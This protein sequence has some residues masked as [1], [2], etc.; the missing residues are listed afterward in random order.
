MDE[1]KILTNTHFNTN[2]NENPFPGLRAFKGTESHLFFGREENISDVLA[3][4]D[5]SHFVAVV[6]TSGTGK[7]SLIKAGVLPAIIAAQRGNDN[8]E[9]KVISISPGSSPIENLAKAVCQN[10]SLV[11]QSNAA[12]Y[13]ANLLD[14]MNDNPLGLVQ[15]MRPILKSTEKLLI[16]V[17]Q[18]EEVFRF[19]SEEA[20]E[21]RGE[22]DKFVKLIID[23]VRQ[24]DVPI[25]AIL[26]LRSDFLGDCVA[27]EGLPEAINDG[28]YLVPK[29]TK[30]QLKRA[31]TGPIDYSNGKIS[32]RL[33]QHITEYLGS[34]ANSDQLPI[35]QHAMMRCWD[36]WKDHE[37]EGEPLDIKHFKAIGDLE[38]AMSNH[39]NEAF[40]ELDP[41]LQGTIEKVFK[42]L[43]TKKTDNRGVRRPMSLENLIKVT[44]ASKENIIASIAPF[45]KHGRSF[46]LPGFLATPPL[47]T[48]YDISHESL[49]RGWDRLTVWV[50][51]EMESAEFYG[52]I[53]TSALLHKSGASA[54]WRNPE[55]QFALDWKE[56]QAPIE[57]WGELYNSNY[58]EGLQF[59][60]DSRTANVVE[61]KKKT[62][63]RRLVRISL[64]VF[65]LVIS[66][67]AAWALLQTEVAQQKTAESEEKSLEAIEQ[68]GLAEDAKQEAQLA[69]LKAEES[70]VLA[71][72]EALNAHEQEIV[73]RNQGQIALIEKGKALTAAELA[74]SKQKLADQKSEEAN[75]QKKKALEASYEA[76]RLR[77]IA[78]GQNLANTSTQVTQNPTLASLLAIQS[79][80]FL[81]ANKGNSNAANLYQAGSR[82]IS[83]ME[84]DHNHVV[85]RHGE[86]ILE[87]DARN[88]KI[89]FVD[90]KSTALTFNQADLSV[91]S[92][93][94]SGEQPTNLNTAYLSPFKNQYVVGLNSNKLALYE[95]GGA[96]RIKLF[97]GHTGLVRSVQFRTS[98]PSMISG[99]RDSTLIL[100]KTD[101]SADKIKLNARI[102]SISALSNT[103]TCLVG[104]EN[105]STYVVNLNDKKYNQFAARPA[106]RVEAISQSSFGD[107][108]AITYSD[109][110]TQVFNKSGKKIKELRGVGSPVDIIIDKENDLMI[111]ASSAKLIRLY[112]LSNLDLLPIEIKLDRQIKVLALESKTK[113]LYVYCS[114]RTIYKYP[115]KAKDI[116]DA[117]RLETERVLTV[118]EWT[119]F[120]GSDVPYLSNTPKQTKTTAK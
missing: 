61:I 50:D 40:D 80:E 17:D 65:F 66:G 117:L 58:N 35:L 109:G 93:V 12:A 22:Y 106:A 41:S 71:E 86:E 118:E 81:L 9:W 79:Y 72:K 13:E 73:A 98:E 91:L 3:K 116:I 97:A 57:A 32:P 49:M 100:W 96:Q 88:N 119:T 31:I 60:E 62:N 26:T 37:L 75:Y 74:Q 48:I 101:G 10:Q 64:L 90:R 7:S 36:Y 19:A 76:Q 21:S 34:S 15:A 83:Q 67:L 1:V 107:I 2:L 63:R 20:T 110:I 53:C 33:I 44:Q 24:R 70:R 99:G 56:K 39:A 52:R 6:G 38:N 25:Y 30:A 94:Q 87:L 54:L 68:R 69:S 95:N 42:A 59:I 43:T 28:H 55:L 4:L 104:C 115:I 112:T 85:L 111:V 16:L 120:I 103:N 105:G 5:H 23:T 8:D 77:L 78:L 51:E 14:L 102:K 113:Q 82:A 47:N 84:T 27:F 11:S 45:Q 114:D 89:V 92:K 46:I 108:F 18:F 29:M